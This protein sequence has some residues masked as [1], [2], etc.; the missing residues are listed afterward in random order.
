MALLLA[1][2]GTQVSRKGK[3]KVDPASVFDVTRGDSHVDGEPIG[4]EMRLD[5]E[6][7]IPSVVTLGARK[8]RNV[9]KTLGG[10]AGTCKSTHVRYPI[11]K[12]RYDGF[13]SHHYAYMSKF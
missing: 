10:D 7:E 12:L 11:D 9:V 2:S 13:S 6:L 1:D 3:E 4:L 5:E 8:S